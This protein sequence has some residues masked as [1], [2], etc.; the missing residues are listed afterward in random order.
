MLVWL[1]LLLLLA[2]VERRIS[3]TSPFIGA[4]I[5]YN[6]TYMDSYNSLKE[7]VTKVYHGNVLI[8]MPSRPN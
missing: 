3:G 7:K 1:L 2:F 8:K 5:H 6:K 4:F